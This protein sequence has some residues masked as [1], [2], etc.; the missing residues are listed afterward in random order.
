M[1]TSEE[2]H[3]QCA[4]IGEHVTGTCEGSGDVEPRATSAEEPDGGNL[5]VR[6]WRGAGTGN[7][8]AY[9]TTV[10]W[11]RCLRERP[12][13]APTVRTSQH[14]GVPLPWRTPGSARSLGRAARAMADAAPTP[15]PAFLPAF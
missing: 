6:I 2:N 1:G 13:G 10:F 8:P 15:F 7:L 4:D 9:S 12:A 5:L 11:P 14:L 3:V